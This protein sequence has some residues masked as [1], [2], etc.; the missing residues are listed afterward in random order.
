MTNKLLAAGSVALMGAGTLL[1]AT[2]A[3]AFT[4]AE[5]ESAPSAGL[6]TAYDN[7]CEV[8]FLEGGDEYTFTTPAEYSDMWVMLVGAG[9]GA[10][11]NNDGNGYAGGGGDVQFFDLSE[12]DPG[13]DL[14][15]EVGLGGSTNTNNDASGEGGESWVQL[16][17]S[18][19][20][21]DGGDNNNGFGVGWG[22]CAP[23]GVSLGYVAYVGQGP[24]Y[25]DAGITVPNGGECGDGA[26]G[27]VPSEESDTPEIFGD[28]EFEI[29][30]GGDVIAGGSE[31]PSYGE[32]ANVLVGL[33]E[34]TMNGAGGDGLVVFRWTPNE[35][36]STGVDA[37]PLGIAAAG[38][39]VA[40]GVGLAIARR[41]R[42]SQ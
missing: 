14:D 11:G 40:G 41:S 42:R 28:L 4:V 37:A 15:L 7:Y 22:Y 34:V 1:G 33:S 36:A 9:G 17:L 30:A 27:Y 12:V 18:R 3:N 20:A 35:L 38:M 8:A 29:G 19:L 24:S 21:A 23:P 26:P 13:T 32:G 2:A 39:L 25:F 5:C 31:L 10:S 6:P 16:P